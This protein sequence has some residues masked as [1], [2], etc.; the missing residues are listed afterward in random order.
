MWWIIWFCEMNTRCTYISYKF[1]PWRSYGVDMLINWEAVDLLSF[2]FSLA[3]FI[4][5]PFLWS[6]WNLRARRSPSD[7]QRALC[8]CQLSQVWASSFSRR[9]VVLSP[10]QT[11]VNPAAPSAEKRSTL[12]NNMGMFLF[13]PHGLCPC[14]PVPRWELCPHYSCNTCCR[15]KWFLK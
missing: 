7:L 2:F 4:H 1:T 12:T 9:C 3:L 15:Q 5:Y 6:H 14:R 10:S 11:C 8:K 13:S